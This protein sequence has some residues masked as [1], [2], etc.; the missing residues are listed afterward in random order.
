MEPSASTMAEPA[1]QTS[2]NRSA[3]P[4]AVSRKGRGRWILWLIA[5]GILLV[6]SLWTPRS[7]FV[8]SAVSDYVRI[9]SV[10][11]AVSWPISLSSLVDESG[12]SRKVP[13]AAIVLGDSV[14][15]ALE[16]SGDGPL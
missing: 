9:S 14:T 7:T 5:F 10:T 15:V 12:M 16:R 1:D 13:T 2:T 6:L 3:D 8:V 4:P 11:Q